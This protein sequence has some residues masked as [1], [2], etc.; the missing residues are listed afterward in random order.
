MLDF[1]IKF[2]RSL[3]A[4]A[5]AI[6]FASLASARFRSSA[7]STPA[8]TVISNRAEATYEGDEGTPYSTVSETVTFTVRPVATLTVSPK[9]TVPSA[10]VVP[11][12]QVTRL[13]R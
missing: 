1:R 11:Q 10:S 13:F 2:S 6:L 7:D 12:E 9:E 8:G 4:I 3:S 5:V